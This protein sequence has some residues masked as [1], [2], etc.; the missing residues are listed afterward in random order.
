MP[1]QLITVYLGC[2]IYYVTP[3]DVVSAIFKSPCISGYYYKISAV[4][5]R[6]CEG[7]GGIWDG[8]L[9]TF[10]AEPE[11]DEYRETFRGV[12]IYWQPAYN[13]FWAQVA[14]GNVAVG[15]TIEEIKTSISEILDFLEP[16][17]P[18]TWAWPLAGVQ[19]WFETLY[20]KVVAGPLSALQS[21]WTTHIMPKLEW[22]RDQIDLTINW[23]WDKI[24][25]VISGIA[26]T[27]GNVRDDLLWM[28]SMVSRMITDYIAI[29]FGWLWDKI[30]PA[31]TAVVTKMTD[32]RD[33][34][35][36]KVRNVL[37]DLNTLVRMISSSITGYL[38]VLIE[39]LWN[40]ITTTLSN[41]SNTLW[42][43]ITAGLDNVGTWIETSTNAIWDS[44]LGLADDLLGGMATK[45]GESLSGFFD[46][47]LKSLGNT[48]EMIFG[49]VNF[50]ISKVRD[51]IITLMAGF[52]DVITNAMSSGSPPQELLVASNVLMETAWQKQIS[53]IDAIHHSDP[54][55]ED[56]SQTAWNI[57]S[58]LLLAGATV[59]GTGLAADFA[60]PLSQMGF[61]ATTRELVYWSGIPS[62]TA[63]IAT[64][65]AAIGIVIGLR[66][67]FMERWTP[68]IPPATDIIR[69]SVREVYREDRREALL[70]NYPGAEYQTLIAKQGFKPE[71]A[72]HYWMAHWILP[73]V[74]QLNEMLYRGKITSDIWRKYVEYN[75]LI[76][77]M[78]PKLE[79][80][81]YKPYTRV[82]I[83]RMW[84]I[85]VVT[86]EEVLE[87]YLWL[88]YDQEHAERMTL[89]TKAYIIAGDVRSL[90]SKGWIDEAAATQMLVDVGIPAERVDVFMKRIVKTEQATRMTTERDLTKTDIMRML[91]NGIFTSTETVGL[92]MDIGY[93]EDEATYLVE[94]QLYQPEIELRELSMSN[95][96]KAYRYET[97]TRDEAKN[98][99]IESGWTESAA[100]AL[101]KLEDAK[102][103]EAQTERARERDL[104]RTDIIKGLK[105]EIITNET[106][107]N[108]LGYLGYSDWEINFIFTLEGI[109]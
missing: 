22:V 6:I 46:S 107:Y 103:L 27:L 108:Y 92:L 76:P 71:F 106:G 39:W 105:A 51:G 47:M 1:E 53:M 43:A 69:F 11:P 19:E 37:E 8:I 4:K 40:N 2:P 5:K 61:R 70:V 81:I 73:S 95:I 50:V 32:V 109:T 104:T 91:K 66:Y 55:G 102:L 90:Y 44:V 97:Y 75:D 36:S 30:E 26:T 64:V 17:P 63:A 54:S 49:A 96:L 3:P 82:D 65:P 78:I 60:N 98:A 72:E 93:D 29:L 101:L 84:D 16:A 52:M 57:Q 13:R 86:D 12:D 77:E 35:W 25:L 7:Q 34:I 62:V 9:C 21:F 58:S 83:R 38:A 99:L 79:E 88:G 10:E 56:I 85:G 24:E 74:G 31:I 20:N 100:E 87:N 41:V 42:T 59:L 68:M 80:I 23:L 28:L 48:A 45:L 15:D 67:W 94:L 14:A 33:Y 18:A 89:W